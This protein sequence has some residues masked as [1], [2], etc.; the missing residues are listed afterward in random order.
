MFVG[1]T[2]AKDLPACEGSDTSLW[3]D[4]FGSVEYDENHIYIGEWKYGTRRGQGTYTWP[5]G[6]KYVGGFYDSQR[7]G[8]GTNFWSDGRI[9]DGW[10]YY[11][12]PVKGSI[13]FNVGSFELEFDELTS[14]EIELLN[15]HYQY[16]S[17]KLSVIMK[18]WNPP[19]NEAQCVDFQIHEVTDMKTDSE[20]RESTFTDW[21]LRERHKDNCGGSRSTA[22]RISEVQVISGFQDMRIWFSKWCHVISE[23]GE[24]EFTEVQIDVKFNPSGEC[25]E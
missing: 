10:F 1:F 18:S 25:P 5:S 23:D 20:G 17:K 12:T 14:S 11:N 4:C 8:K 7:H 2:T 13:P 9:D 3:T 6:T 19:D 24:K 21:T 15:Q 22:P 16:I